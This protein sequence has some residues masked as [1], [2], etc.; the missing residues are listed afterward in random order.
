M[1]L[2]LKAAMPVVPLVTAEAV[3]V[4]VEVPL[5]RT[6]TVRVGHLLRYYLSAPC[7]H[8]MYCIRSR[9]LQCM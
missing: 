2:Q 9:T 3:A 8:G 6:V 7:G 4:A 1:L 5:D